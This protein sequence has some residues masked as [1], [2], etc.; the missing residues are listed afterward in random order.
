ML[1]HRFRKDP[2]LVLMGFA[3][4]V[5]LM[6]VSG[7]IKEGAEARKEILQ[8][9]T[10]GD[11]RIFTEPF[12]GRSDTKEVMVISK[13]DVPVVFLYNNDSNEVDRLAITSGKHGI[14][15]LTRLTKSGISEFVL[16]GN[17]VHDGL[18]MPVFTMDVSDKPGVWDK[19]RYTPT[20]AG[21][22]DKGKLVSYRVVGEVYHDIDFDG[23]F[24]AKSIY[25]E[26]SVVCSESIFVDEQWLELGYREPDGRWKREGL[27][28]ADKL[29]AYTVEGKEKVYFDFV[30]GKGWHRQ[31]KHAVQEDSENATE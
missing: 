17:E 24:D 29:R 26:K 7:T 12:T 8:R 9:N 4:G 16:L 22:Y 2:T 23:Q 28:E 18:R 20:V 15:A 11:L 6:L 5:V 31:P 25:D 21:V 30:W 14:M 1:W 19:V 3:A 27:F 13:G 10:F